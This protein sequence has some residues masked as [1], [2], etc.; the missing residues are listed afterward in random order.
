MNSV[1][2]RRVKMAIAIIVLMV[3]IGIVPINETTVFGEIAD[4]V[5]STMARLKAMVKG[6]EVS[7]AENTNRPIDKSIIIHTKSSVYSSPKI[8]SLEDFLLG[9]NISFNPVTSGTGK[10]AVIPSDIVAAL[11][12]FLQS[13]DSY[14]LVASPSILAYSGQEAMIAIVNTAGAAITAQQ[15][16]NELNINF[17]FHNGQDGYDINEIELKNGEALLISGIK[18]DIDDLMTILVLPEVE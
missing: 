15:H 4:N 7:E 5:T 10:H 1:K 2:S 14:G 17:A 3:C 12:E 16:G 6:E 11:Q 18:N 9:Q 8:S 13:S